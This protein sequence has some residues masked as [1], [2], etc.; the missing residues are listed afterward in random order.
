MNDL[1]VFDR[2]ISKGMIGI[3]LPN[4]SQQKERA[5]FELKKLFFLSRNKTD[6]SKVSQRTTLTSKMC[7]VRKPINIVISV[8]HSLI[9]ASEVLYQNTFSAERSWKKQN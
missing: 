1:P 3:L 4:F 5:F 2:F 8:F 6:T 7:P 9:R